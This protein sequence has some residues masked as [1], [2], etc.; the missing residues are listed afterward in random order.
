MVV[1]LHISV[2]FDQQI[3]KVKISTNHIFELHSSNVS[4]NIRNMHHDEARRDGTLRDTVRPEVGRPTPPA[5]SQGN[6]Q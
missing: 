5:T 3:E 4:T 2:S 6:H 1:E